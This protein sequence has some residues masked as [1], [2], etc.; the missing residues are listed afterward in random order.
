MKKNIL[1]VAIQK[2]ILNAGMIMMMIAGKNLK[3]A[4]RIKMKNAI[5]VAQQV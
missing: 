1:S 4:K 5:V 3:S 2:D